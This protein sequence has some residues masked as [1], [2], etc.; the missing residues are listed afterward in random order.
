MNYESFLLIFYSNIPLFIITWIITVSLYFL[1]F[2]RYIFSVIDPLFYH[3]FVSSSG[4]SIIFSLWYLGYIDNYYLYNFLIT[5]AFFILGFYVFKPIKIRKIQNSMHNLNPVNITI[6]AKTLY[7]ISGLIFIITNYALYVLKGIPLLMESRLEAGSGGYGIFIATL[8][9]TTA[10]M[11]AFI[12]LKIFVLK[13]KIN[14]IDFFFLANILIHT[15]L[16]GSRSGILNFLF[17]SFYIL[18]FIKVKRQIDIFSKLKFKFVFLISFAIL[19][20]LF[21]FY[22]TTKQNPLFSL[23]FRILMTGDIYIMAYVNDNINLIEGDFLSHF[24]GP[25]L[26][27]FKIIS[28]NEVPKS[29]GQQLFDYIYQTDLVAGPNARMNIIALK[30]FGEFSFLYS[31]IVGLVISFIRNKSIYL[32]KDNILGLLIY[33][34]LSLPVLS[35]ETDIFYAIFLYKT[36]FTIGLF[37]ILISVII[38]DSF[39]S[40]GKHNGKNESLWHNSYLQS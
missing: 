35:L 21:L 2:K 11:L 22:L 12:F 13:K 18:L 40:G 6:F 34:F 24:I 7:L 5:Q 15:I 27:G 26:A 19:L 10:I 4:F 30:F 1:I 28:W 17:I 38:S 36:Y 29:I 16:S 20:S 32:I 39:K 23:I 25:I 31:F 37:L 33:L 14:F 9:T 3:T 8:S